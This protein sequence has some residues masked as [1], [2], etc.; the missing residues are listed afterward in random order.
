MYRG[1][2]RDAPRGV[3]RETEED[4]QSKRFIEESDAIEREELKRRQSM[5][6]L[7]NSDKSTENKI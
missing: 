5:K 2:E 4:E 7:R 6:N 1:S 3:D